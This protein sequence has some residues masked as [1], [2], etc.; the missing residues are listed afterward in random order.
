MEQTLIVFMSDNG[1]AKGGFRGYKDEWP[2]Q[3]MGSTGGLRGHKQDQTEGGI[4]IPFITTWPGHIPGNTVNETPVIS[5]DLYPTFAAAGNA[6]TLGNPH[7]DGINLLPMLLD[8]T[9]RMRERP[10]FWAS[11]SEQAVRFGDFKWYRKINQP[12]ELY[13]LVRDPF[14]K[15]NVAAER[16]AQA[17]AMSRLHAT[18]LDQMPPHTDRENPPILKPADPRPLDPVLTRELSGR[19]AGD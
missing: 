11:D 15:H 9:I 1:P 5:L 13:D 2:R 8:H 16:E 4:R 6:G 19:A 17:T 3:I 12:A 18:W 14:E 7:V 10:L